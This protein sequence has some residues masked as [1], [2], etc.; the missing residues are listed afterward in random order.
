VRRLIAVSA[1]ALLLSGL[2]CQRPGGSRRLAGGAALDAGADSRS[3]AEPAADAGGSEDALPDIVPTPEDGGDAAADAGPQRLPFPAPTILEGVGQWVAVG[4]VHGDLD[5]TRTALQ[6][7][8]VLD[9]SDR[10][11]GGDR[12]VVQVGD[13]LDRGDEE[14]AVLA[15]LERLAEEAHEAGGALLVLN[16]NHETMNVDEDFRYVTEGGWLDFADVPH[17]ASDPALAEYPEAERGRVAAFLPGGPY[18]RKLARQK[19]AVVLGDTVFVHGGLLPHHVS[20]GLDAMNAAFSAW[21]ADEGPRPDLVSSEDSPVWIRDYSDE[22]DEVDCLVLQETLDLLGVERMV[23]AHTPRAAIT[24]ECGGRV[25]CVDVGMS[26]YYGGIPA[27][28][29]YR[30]GELSVVSVDD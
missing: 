15:L 12:I 14:R 4:D 2:A 8:G 26:E 22:P 21:M 6:L 3:A 13:Q 10:W 30:L 11:S 16:G 9:A 24:A 18:A 5:A 19:V 20:A 1:A 29:S 17:D 25:W 28:L 7:A 27:V 23:V